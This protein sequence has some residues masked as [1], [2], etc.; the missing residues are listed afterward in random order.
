MSQINELGA[1]SPGQPVFSNTIGGG[2]ANGTAVMAK[3]ASNGAPVSLDAG[4]YSF[5]TNP[6]PLLPKTAAAFA[7]V[8]GGPVAGFPVANTAVV[9]VDN[10]I[11]R[12][13]GSNFTAGGSADTARA[14]WP[15]QV[16]TACRGMGIPVYVDSW[17][18]SGSATA[19]T[20]ATMSG[21]DPRWTYTGAPTASALAVM[22]I[23]GNPWAPV[24]SN[25]FSFLPDTRQTDSMEL[26]FLGRP[27]YTGTYSINANGGATI[28]A[29]IASTQATDAYY[30]A[31]AKTT[32]LGT[33]TWNAVCS[34]GTGS[35]VGMVCRN[36]TVPEISIYNVA[37]GSALTANWTPS[38]TFYGA[39]NGLLALVAQGGATLVH[40]QLQVNDEKLT[41]QITPAQLTTNL[42]AIYTALAAVGAEVTFGSQSP[43]AITG[44][45][46]IPY[47]DQVI[48]ANA[49]KTAAQTTGCL[50]FDNFSNFPTYELGVTASYGY[51]QA[52]ELIH[53]NP[54]GQS[55]LASPFIQ[56]M[57]LL[58]GTN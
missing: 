22:S 47:A 46:G 27:S 8:R 34:A 53:P 5:L 23:G 36:S 50:Y 1:G 28:G 43:I 33:N 39:M 14:A 55:I 49:I 3:T 37:A 10:S 21:T 18:G 17:F 6:L 13:L 32:T 20:P 35:L 25:T 11:G 30:K 15:T 57:R 4:R 44:A 26:W 29:A 12:G 58:W 19:S 9:I 40:I 54:R 51:Y 16:A 56:L 31:A 45:N 2:V 38:S 48:Y 42:V 24:G 7:K 41:T 52:G